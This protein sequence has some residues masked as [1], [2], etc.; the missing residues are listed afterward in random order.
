MVKTGLATQHWSGKSEG[1]TS[2]ASMQSMLL[3]GGLGTCPQENFNIT[4]SEIESEAIFK[5]IYIATGVILS[6]AVH[7]LYIAICSF[8]IRYVST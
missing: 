8:I 7:M 6:L 3:L 4:H 1:Y 2:T 5:I